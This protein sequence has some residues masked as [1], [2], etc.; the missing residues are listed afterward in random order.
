MPSPKQPWPIPTRF[1]S[2]TPVIDPEQVGKR[3][4]NG[5]GPVLEQK[6]LLLWGKATSQLICPDTWQV[7]VKELSEE[8]RVEL[9]W[10]RVS[11]M[12][13]W[14]KLNG[15]MIIDGSEAGMCT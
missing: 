12:N 13:F 14:N 11:C 7:E 15:I 2:F 1:S 5:H 4:A 9:R 8:E 3:L 6:L 10:T